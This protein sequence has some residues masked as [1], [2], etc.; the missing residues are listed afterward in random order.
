MKENL[1]VMVKYSTNTN[2]NN[3][4]LLKIKKRPGHMALE[5]QG[6]AWDMNKNVAWFV[7][8]IDPNPPILICILY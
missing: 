1:T 8:L 5:I 6:L 3:L 2:D 7:R 4:K